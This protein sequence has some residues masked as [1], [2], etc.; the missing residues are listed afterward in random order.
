MPC[1]YSKYPSNWRE[2]RNGILLRA[3]G[4][5]GGDPREGASCEWCGAFNHA[6]HPVTGSRV[7][8]TIAHINDPSPMNVDSDNLAALC[9][10]CHNT[11]DAPMR[12]RNA[13][14]RRRTSEITSGQLELL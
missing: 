12:A 2:I 11:H 4:G 7:V 6:L 1:D 3:G 5:E 10:K 8:L 14:I 9:Q 13:A